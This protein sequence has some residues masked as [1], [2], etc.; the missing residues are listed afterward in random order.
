[1][2]SDRA[3]AETASA[4]L[5]R[6]SRRADLLAVHARWWGSRFVFA[7]TLS[8]GFFLAGFLKDQPRA[9]GSRTGTPPRAGAS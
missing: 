3:A 8:I 5:S 2:G 1:M 6:E 9:R 4:T 7:M